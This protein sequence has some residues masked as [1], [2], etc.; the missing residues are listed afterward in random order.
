MVV[1]DERAEEAAVQSGQEPPVGADD[2]GAPADIG[3][4]LPQE[5]ARRKK[6][7]WQLGKGGEA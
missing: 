5:P 4:R 7:W 3:Q 6:R 2:P 1:I